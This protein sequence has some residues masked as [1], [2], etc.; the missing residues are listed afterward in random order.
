MGEK[1]K[2]IQPARQ[3]RWEKYDLFRYGK[4]CCACERAYLGGAVYDSHVGGGYCR[5]QKWRL[6]AKCHWS[7]MIVSDAEEH[8][9][10]T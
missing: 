3:E 4:P 7:T 2:E 9:A 10:F 6:T 1:A 8:D 5:A